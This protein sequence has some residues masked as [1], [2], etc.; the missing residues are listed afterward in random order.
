MRENGLRPALT[1]KTNVPFY[2]RYLFSKVVK[3]FIASLQVNNMPI[4][5]DSSFL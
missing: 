5:L 4:S 2:V 3:A 1:Q